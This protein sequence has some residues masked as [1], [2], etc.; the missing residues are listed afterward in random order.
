MVA[1]LLESLTFIISVAVI[2]SD[3]ASTCAFNFHK[4]KLGRSIL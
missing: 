3:D 2:V 1:R 4:S